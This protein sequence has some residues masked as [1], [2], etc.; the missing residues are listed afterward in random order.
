MATI[1]ISDHYNGPGLDEGYCAGHPVPDQLR[2]RE[3]DGHR[4]R[5]PL[6]APTTRDRS[7]ALSAGSQEGVRTVVGITQFEVFDGG[8]DG[9]IGTAGNTVFMRQECSFRKTAV[10]SDKRPGRLFGSGPIA[11]TSRRTALCR[12]VTL[13]LDLDPSSEETSRRERLHP[14]RAARRHLDH[15]HPGRDRDPLVLES[16]GQGDDAEAKSVVVSAAQALEVCS[17]ERTRPMRAA[18]SARCRT[19]SRRSATR[20]RGST[21]RRARTPTA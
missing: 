15:R 11:D 4:G 2:L 5:W 6:L 17:S 10:V 14:D 8:A 18:R 21:S 7:C 12:S 19:S 1:R 3:H 20:A 16:A 9:E 13:R